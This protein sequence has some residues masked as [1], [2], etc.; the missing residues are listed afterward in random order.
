[1]SEPTEPGEGAHPERLGRRFFVGSLY[2]GLGA[3]VT[4]GLNFVLNLAIARVLGPEIL[5]F[6]A[7]VHS[8]NLLISMIGSFSP[9]LAVIQAREESQRLYDAAF[10][11]ALALAAIGFVV[12]LGVA[13]LLGELHSPTAA[14]FLLLFAVIRFPS[15]LEQIPIARLERGLRYRAVAGVN[16]LTG[17]LPNLLALGVALLGA[18]AWSLLLRDAA[19]SFLGFGLML[20]LSGYRYRRQGDRG[21]RE[22]V[23][24]FSRPMFLSRTLETVLDRVDRL[25]VGSFLGDARLGLYHQSRFLAESGLVAAR[26]FGRLS[27][28]LYSRL[29]D[30]PVRLARA[31]ELINTFLVRLLFAGSATLLVA[32]EETVRL[33]LGEEW[34]EAAPLLRVLALYA[35]LLP[36]FEN[37]K[38]LLLG[39]G[40]V[41]RSVELRL[42]QLAVLL[43]GVGAGIAVEDMRVVAGGQLASV[44]VG[45][46]LAAWSNR[47]VVASRATRLFG[48]PGLCLALASLASWWALHQGPGA[49]L[50]RAL[51]PFVPPLFYGL[52]LAVL[53][54][55]RLARELRYLRA[56]AAAEPAL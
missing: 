5:G 55:R 56:V 45:V 43:V 51:W 3:W 1:M 19:M 10:E 21:S 2:L 54:G 44:A 23:M 37:M 35:G 18:G 22:R 20:A 24:A 4:S 50:P 34:V 17:N 46:A 31:Y 38:Q 15:F 30:D 27:F 29:Q 40:E 42:V 12:S 26:P 9:G 36:L 33:L 49:E 47:G 6:Y 39:R 16:L 13:P 41:R 14:W 48:T 32:P 52:G 53:E 7:L 8:I 25:L 11:I 28:N